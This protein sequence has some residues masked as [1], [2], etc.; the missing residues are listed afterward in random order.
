MTSIFP[1]IPK[2]VFTVFEPLSLV[3]GF[4]GAVLSPHFFVTEQI[5]DTLPHAL[6][7]NEHVLALQLGNTYLLLG[8]IGV[9]VL[10]A[11]TDP[12]IAR[13][14]IFAC[15]LGDI[16]HLAVTYHV[17][18]RDKYFDVAGWNAMA[19][20]NIGTTVSHLDFFLF[21]P[22]RAWLDDAQ[23][24]AFLWTVRTLYLLG[25]LGRD[26]IPVGVARGEKT[27]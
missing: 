23:D 3:A 9:L 7:P 27:S 10:Y 22:S 20:G 13:N 4:V 26:R 6:N 1:P 19:W 16:G 18:G 17:L 8:I 15:W 2:F 11:T 21:C 24:Q 25:F 12:K 5:I 14:Y